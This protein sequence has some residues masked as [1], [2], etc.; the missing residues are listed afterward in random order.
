MK[1]PIIGLT[2][3]MESGKSTA[4]AYLRKHHGYAGSNLTDPMDEMLTPLLR[5]MKVPDHEIALRLSGSMKNDPIPGFDW[6]SGR[7]LKQAL[8]REFRD[9]VSRPDGQ[10][11]TD[12]GLFHDLWRVDNENHP[13]LVHE[14]VRYAF[15]ADLIRR[16]GGV[17]Y[18]LVD[19]EKANDAEGQEKHESEIIDFPVDAVIM[20]PKTGTDRLHAEIDALVGARPSLEIVRS[21]TT[22]PVAAFDADIDAA[23]NDHGPE[24]RTIA[25]RLD[26][27]DERLSEM[28]DDVSADVKDRLGADAA[29]SA[30]DEN[31]AYAIDA[32]SSWVTDNISNSTS[33]RR[34]AAVYA[35]L[36][37][38]EAVKRIGDVE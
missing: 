11:G 37:R 15:E 30:T 27:G 3:E 17:V 34:V 14:Q 5:R 22:D 23:I 19:P 1:P 31:A 24:I 4:A 6:L 16:D 10:G 8:G 12:R 18:K 21:E 28:L 25:D 32:V 7:K 2:G 29:N 20:N 36:G 33:D 13:F 38:D 9:V 35:F 26:A